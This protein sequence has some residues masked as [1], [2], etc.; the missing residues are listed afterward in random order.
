MLLELDGLEVKSSD[1]FSIQR[2]L[3]RSKKVGK[4]GKVGRRIRGRIRREGGGKR[5]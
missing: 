1:A 4:V 2:C 3:G 5:R